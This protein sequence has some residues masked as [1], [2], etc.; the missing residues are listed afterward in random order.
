[1]LQKNTYMPPGYGGEMEFIM[2]DSYKGRPFSDERMTGPQQIPGEVYCAYYDLGGEGVAYHDSDAVNHGSGELNPVNGSYLHSF[3]IDE[4]VDTSY[5]KY[6]DETDNNP[7]NKVQPEEGLLYVGW[8]VPGEWFNVTVQVTES[9]LYDIDLMYTSN[10]GGTISLS[11]DGEDVAGRI[12][13]EST[14]HPDD[15]L[16]WRQ[17]HHWNMSTIAKGILLVEGLRVL[18]IKT[19]ENG[20]MNYAFLSFKKVGG[21]SAA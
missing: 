3:R 16:D 8:T 1:M 12:V 11:M 7:Y 20:N 2:I 14:Y 9:G 15:P 10:E 17:W 5:V 4:G 13:I 6:F 18:T 21:T 19:L